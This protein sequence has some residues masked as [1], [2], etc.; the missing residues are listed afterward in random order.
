VLCRTA[1]LLLIV[2]G[3]VRAQAAAADPLHSRECIAAR[4]TLARAQ[5]D[6]VA[7]LEGA[8]GRL[9]HAR[10]QAQR[11]CLGRDS[12]NAQ[13]VGAPDPPIAV[14]PPMIE[15][16]Q[17]QRGVIAT[18]SSPLLDIPRP[19][20]ITICDPGGCWDSEGRRLNRVGPLLLGPRGGA[21]TTQ[22]SVVQC[23]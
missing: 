3:C 9:A 15:A 14:A 4:E 23:P 18:P 8:P 1:A 12:G 7:R 2:A 6:A 22:G 21:C 20:A 5:Q 10:K 19:S 17:P 11:A 16:P 13:R